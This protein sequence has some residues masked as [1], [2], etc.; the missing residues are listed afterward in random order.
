MLR[1]TKKSPPPSQ[2]KKKHT[3]TNQSQK[4]LTQGTR[5][6]H[7]HCRTWQ[8]EKK[9]M[10]RH[11]LRG[12]RVGEASLPG[13]PRSRLWVS[14]G[15]KS[16]SRSCDRINKRSAHD[17][18]LVSS[19]A[20]TTCAGH[21][22]L[23]MTVSPKFRLGHS[24]VDAIKRTE[25]LPVGTSSTDRSVQGQPSTL[26]LKVFTPSLVDLQ[27]CSLFAYFTVNLPDIYGGDEEGTVH[28]IDQGEGDEQGDAP[29][30]LTRPATP[31]GRAKRCSLIWTTSTTEPL[32]PA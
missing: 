4:R 28:A 17:E 24:A 3:K 15:I 7:Q 25:Q 10:A 13:P 8:H 21:C 2:K 27:H 5:Q 32:R 20:G 18:P 16:R 29:P 23:G 30:F 31:F 6:P 14:R 22:P 26:T 12:K 1:K 11:V 19:V 9:V